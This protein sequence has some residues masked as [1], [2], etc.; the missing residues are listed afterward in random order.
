MFFYN[1]SYRHIIGMSGRFGTVTVAAKAVD[2]QR[3]F[4]DLNEVTKEASMLFRLK[5]PNIVSPHWYCRY[6][7]EH[8][9]RLSSLVFL[10][11]GGWPY[12]R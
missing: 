6:C 7:S 4:E 9:S 12:H 8:I 10:Y 1:G 5:H 2:S 3:H 11:Q